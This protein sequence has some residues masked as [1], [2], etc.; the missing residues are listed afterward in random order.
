MRPL[1]SR[2]VVRCSLKCNRRQNIWVNITNLV[3]FTHAAPDI[4]DNLWSWPTIKRGWYN[5]N[6]SSRHDEANV[7]PLMILLDHKWC[8]RTREFQKVCIINHLRISRNRCQICSF[9]PNYY[10]RRYLSVR[11]PVSLRV[12]QFRLRLVGEIKSATLLPSSQGWSLHFSV[13][14][15]MLS[16]SHWLTDTVLLSLMQM[17]LRVMSPPAHGCEHCNTLRYDRQRR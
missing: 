11:K 1:Y 17:T 13:E 15:M 6:F 7:N 2:W 3:I 12:F 5:R 4:F 16:A 14:N 10:I 8:S 9:K